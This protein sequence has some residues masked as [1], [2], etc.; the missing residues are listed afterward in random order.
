MSGDTKPWREGHAHRRPA[1]RHRLGHI[2]HAHTRATRQWDSGD[3]KFHGAT[4]GGGVEFDAATFGGTV[5]FGDATFGGT[6]GFHGPG[7]VLAP[8][9]TKLRSQAGPVSPLPTSVPDES[10]APSQGSGGRRHR[11]S[12]DARTVPTNQRMSN[13]KIGRLRYR[14]QTSALLH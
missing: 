14:H 2:P 11:N 1:P 3:A 8:L 12:I 9:S 13:P 7:S 10:F 6:A 4:F 5:D